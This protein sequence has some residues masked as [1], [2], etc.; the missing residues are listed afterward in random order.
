MKIHAVNIALATEAG[1]PLP[2]PMNRLHV[3]LAKAHRA[4]S[5]PPPSKPAGFEEAKAEA[6]HICRDLGID[7]THQAGAMLIGQLVE[8]KTLN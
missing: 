6:L 7:P 8:H 3:A 1:A 5:R 2:S 4:R